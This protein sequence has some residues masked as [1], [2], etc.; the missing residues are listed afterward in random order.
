MMFAY[1]PFLL[2]FFFFKL[3]NFY[4]LPVAFQVTLFALGFY[5]ATILAGLICL[6]RLGVCI[7]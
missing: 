6:Y 7:D 2:L 1:N 4:V 5:I 3:Y